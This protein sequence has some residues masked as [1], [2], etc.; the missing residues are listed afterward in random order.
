MTASRKLIS[1]MI[2]V[3]CLAVAWM[4]VTNH[5]ITGH[6]NQVWS[7]MRVLE[8]FQ[9]G[10]GKDCAK[11]EIAACTL[12]S[13]QSGMTIRAYCQLENG[14][15]LMGIWGLAAEGI[16]VTGY[17]LDYGRWL[18]VCARDGCLEGD[19]TLLQRVLK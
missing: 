7:S 19:I 15:G 16:Y 3:I 2:I 14:Q 17:A 11:L 4:V 18:Q 9:K 13:G 10:G 6:T 5:A 1:I 12:Q 8:R